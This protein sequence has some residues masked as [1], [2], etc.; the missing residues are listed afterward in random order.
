MRFTLSKISLALLSCGAACIAATPFTAQAESMAETQEITTTKVERIAVTGSRIQRSSAATP[1]PTTVIDAE[2][3]AQLGFVNA[4]DILNSLPAI[5]GS[6]GGRSG[7]DGLNDSTAGL[8]LANLRGLGTI[9]TLVLINGR[10]HVGSSVGNTAVDISS[11]PTQMI[12]RVEIIT[13]AA[14]AVYGADA[15]SGV[16]NFILKKAYEGFKGELRRGQT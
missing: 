2:Q 7:T 15:V 10:R 1:V 3:I 12:E 16:V 11:I 14:G 6:L 9:R 13:G 5:S 4:G 8:E